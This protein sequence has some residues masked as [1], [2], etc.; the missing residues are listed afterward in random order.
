MSAAGAE[1]IRLRAVPPFAWFFASLFAVALLAIFA[2]G[3]DVLPGFLAPIGFVLAGAG[4]WLNVAASRA[5]RRH[6]TTTD[7]DG[8]PGTL[9]QDGVYRWTR[10]PMYLGGVLILAGLV[11]VS[12]AITSAIV[13]AL[14]AMVA[15]RHFLPPEERRLEAT[16]ADAYAAYRARVRRWL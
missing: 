11:L 13:P 15:A 5:F 8:Q 1:A 3:P 4:V 10:N 14:Y 12:G 7:P 9:V 16:F 6:A 2:P